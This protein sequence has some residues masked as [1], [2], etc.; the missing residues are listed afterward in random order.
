MSEANPNRVFAFRLGFGLRE[1]LDDLFALAVI[2][3]VVSVVSYHFVLRR[4]GVAFREAIFN[5]PMDAV[6]GVVAL[7]LLFTDINYAAL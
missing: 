5:W 6:A 7:L 4:Q 3:L 2:M 1:A